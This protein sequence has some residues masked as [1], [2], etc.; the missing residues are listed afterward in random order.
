MF[1]YNRSVGKHF[2]N[3][4]AGLNVR[5]THGKST[6]MRYK[7]FQ[8]SNLHSP[9]YAA[10]QDGKASVS[11]DKSRLLGILASVN[12]SYNNIYLFDGSFR[13]DGSSKFGK[14]KRFAPFWSVGAGMNVHNTEWLKDHW[15]ISTLRV[16]GTYGVTGNVNFP[17]YAAIS[18]YKTS[19]K[20]YYATPSNTL[21]ALGN[22]KLTWEK[23]YTVD[24]GMN[25]GLF[26][27]RY[28]L[29][30]SYYRKDTKNQL[31]QLSIRTSSGFSGFYTNAGSVRN[32]GFEIKVTATVL[33]TRDWTVALTGT[34]ASNTNRITKLGQEA[35]RYN[36]NIQDFHN[37][38]NEEGGDG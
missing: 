22:P 17:P 35:E 7:G 14:D 5:E 30:F 32:K 3:A 28:C 27:E 16:R 10:M 24:F 33:Q 23:T 29:E 36:K 26:N 38:K 18:T 19:D 9:T 31:E 34:L 13:L 37:S 4:T 2:I 15:L 20:W 1:Y 8:L 25:L 21:I 11:S 12:Y 6:S